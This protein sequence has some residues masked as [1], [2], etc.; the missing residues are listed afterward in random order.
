M[1]FAIVS[2]AEPKKVYAGPDAGWIPVEPPQQ[3]TPQDQAQRFATKD[4]AD[5]YIQQHGMQAETVEIK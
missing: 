2:K 5:R 3:P 4:D 1:A